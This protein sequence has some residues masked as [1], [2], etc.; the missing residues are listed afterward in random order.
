MIEFKKDGCTYVARE[1]KFEIAVELNK[2]MSLL[3]YETEVVV[4]CDDDDCPDSLV[5]SDL[6]AC[7]AT[8]KHRTEEDCPRTFESAFGPDF[9]LGEAIV[10]FRTNVETGARLGSCPKEWCE[11]ARKF[12]KE[13][14]KINGVVFKAPV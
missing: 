5:P 4:P 1:E 11:G 14:W 7:V 10:S 3:E 6:D 13:D 2:S 9:N 8:C 12:A